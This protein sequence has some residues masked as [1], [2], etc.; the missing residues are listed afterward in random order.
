MSEALPHL[1]VELKH[2]LGA[3]EIDAKVELTQPWTVL[4]GPSGSGKSTILRAIAGLLRPDHARIS[5]RL[6]EQET[7]LTDSALGVFIP[8]HRRPVRWCA[9]SPAL[10]P[11]MTVRQNLR[12]AAENGASDQQADMALER[13]H[14]TRLASARPATL[15]GGEQ[16]RVALARAAVSSNGQLLLLDEPFSGLDVPLRDELLAALREWLA[17]YGTPVL[18]V[19]HDIGEA[20]LLGAEVIRLHQ[21]RVIEQGPVV[22]VLAQERVRLLSQ[23]G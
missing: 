10:F 16:Q 5:V 7:V 12:F 4:F 23:L 14:L 20:F 13:F 6:E 11:N 15:S 1:S 3:L 2:R 21:G 17:K 22:H 8:A 18:S 19:T 9:Q